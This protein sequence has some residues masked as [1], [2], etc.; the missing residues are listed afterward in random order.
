MRMQGMDEEANE[1][2]ERTNSSAVMRMNNKEMD[3]GPNQEERDEEDQD[4]GFRISL[5]IRD[6]S[7][8]TSL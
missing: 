7:A 1:G 4:P 5:R 6:S 2:S 3:R 8:A